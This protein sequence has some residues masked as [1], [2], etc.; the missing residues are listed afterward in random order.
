MRRQPRGD[1][2]LDWDVALAHRPQP[3]ARAEAAARLAE[4]GI[5]AEQVVQVLADGGDDL[6]A[7]SRSGD[8]QWADRF[9]GPLAVALLAAEVGALT[10]HLTSRAAAVRA[11]AVD[12]LL[13]EFSAVS[14]AAA[15]GVSRQKV[16][17]IA[18][19]QRMGPFLDHVP[20]SRP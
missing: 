5:T 14:V 17:D 4:C 9:G 1:T 13:E 3:Q 7:A 8:P 18:R 19:A 10:A 15:L 11:T 6:F 12:A 2:T 20:W 16:Y